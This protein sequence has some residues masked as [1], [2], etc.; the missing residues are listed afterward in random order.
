MIDRIAG[1]AGAEFAGLTTFPALL[2][3]AASGGARITPNVE[4]LAR[5][6]EIA[7]RHPTCP[8]T[9]EINAPGTTSTEVLGLLAE[10]GATQVEPGHGL[11][12]TTPLHAVQDLPEQP[13]VLYLKRGGPCPPGR[14]ALLRR[15][16]V[17]R[18][19]VRRLR[20]A[21]GCRPRPVGGLDGARAGGHA[22]PCRHRLLRQA[23]SRRRSPSG[24]GRDRGS[25][26]SG[27]RPSSPGRSWPASAACPRAGPGWR[28]CGT[29]SGTRSPSG[30]RG[31][32]GRQRRRARGGGPVQVVPG[33][34]GARPCGAEPPLRPGHGPARRTTAQASRRWSSAS[35][36]CMR[37]TREWSGSTGPSS[38]SSR[39]RRPGR[40]ASR[41]SH[42]TLA[43]IDP[44]DVVE[45]LFLNR[46]HTRG[47][48][49]GAWL[50]VLDKKRMR[51]E[52]NE[53]LG[54]LD[55]R[56]PSLRRVDERAVGRPAPGGGHRQGG[57]LGPA[58]RAARRARR[59]A[60]RRAGGPGAR[61]D[62]QPA[63]RG[64]RGAAH[65][66]Q[67][68]PRHRGLRSGRGA[69]PGSQDRGGGRG[70]RN[71]GRPRGLYHRRQNRRSQNH[72]RRVQDAAWDRCRGHQHQRRGGRSE[73]RR[74]GRGHPQRADT[75]DGHAGRC[76]GRDRPDRRRGRPGPARLGWL[77]RG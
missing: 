64:R 50:G 75:G 72:E 70:R 23:S 34:A 60:G 56:I 63:R 21:S 76:R 41:R 27:S 58:D 38:P 2:F 77:C 44:L 32:G 66:P 12:G 17:H 52:S 47:G 37:P 30:V 26:D 45:N 9:L 33:G 61:P 3:D 42:Q 74:A 1:L 51:A 7:R 8:Q 59:R 14:A 43:V 68:G 11:T 39:P 55:I 28:A 5:A 36:A 54:R 49:L 71:Q 4:T 29:A 24:R 35:P 13:A 19:G 25:S 53:I 18:P 6:A 31:E 65:H 16:A 15:G 20:R 48:R 62:P 69:A 22:R 40:W 73:R 10:S 46:E 57:G 67:H